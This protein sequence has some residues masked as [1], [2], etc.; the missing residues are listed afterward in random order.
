M[1][2]DISME[3]KG[4][5]AEKEESKVTAFTGGT[6]LT[7]REPD[8]TAEVL[9]I[10]DGRIVGVGNGSV[11]R[12]FPEAKLVDL[13]GKTLL[14]AFI[15]SHNHLSFGCLIPTW[16]DLADLKTK[17]QY[18]EA[19][20]GFASSHPERGW[21]V[22][23]PWVDAEGGGPIMTRKDID[24]ACPD[25]PVLLIHGT[26]HKLMLN[27][28]ALEVCGIEASTPEPSFGKIVRDADGLTG[29]VWGSEESMILNAATAVCLSDH[30]ALIEKRAHQLLLYGITSVQDP[31]VTPEGMQA[32]RELHRNGRLP[33]SVLV[34]PHGS[35]LFDNGVKGW[36]DGPATGTGD[37]HL[38]V[39]P[40]K[41]FA[42][43][44]LPGQ[45]GMAGR[46]DGKDLVFG[47]PR[48]DFAEPLI[49]CY[50][51]GYQVC[52]HSIGNT[53]TDAV[54]DAFERAKDV[55]PPGF[56]MRPRMEHLFIMGDE[57]IRRLAML[58]GCTSMQPF[59]FARM[60][61]RNVPAFEGTK[62]FPFR[63]LTESGVV[64]SASSDDPGF[65]SMRAID[66]IEN[67]L[68]GKAM[69]DPES[70]LYEPGQAMPFRKWLWSYTAG[71]AYVGG[72]EDERGMLRE[73]LVADLVVLKGDI[74]AGERPVVAETWKDGR[75]VYSAL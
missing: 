63:D 19:I 43:G 37:V 59:F 10:K 21:I 48:E 54:L 70:P 60:K 55:A 17:E 18:L 33:V 28:K 23:F 40:I 16:M 45:L 6:I 11:L 35:G 38:R 4:T 8:E 27:S 24:S 3:N 66:P 74:G 47:R 36:L 51:R 68:I 73:G 15:D 29:V 65:G 34:M 25:R 72:L 62:W 2:G 32:Y 22:G 52:V 41:L 20:A 44:G 61:V 7:M 69:G 1:A 67:A 53:T 42:D 5:G 12:R 46:M 71:A 58:G 39:G 26:I 13:K 57:Q 49:E 9:I 31:G 50:R 30:A 56:V 75:L 14:P 64:M